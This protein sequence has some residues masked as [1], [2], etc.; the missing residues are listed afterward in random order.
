MTTMKRSVLG[1]LILF[2]VSLCVHATHPTERVSSSYAEFFEGEF[3]GV[4]LT[5]DGRLILAPAIVEKLDTLE[6][7]VYSAVVDR[8]GSVFVGTGNNGKKIE[9]SHPIS[10]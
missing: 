9:K 5:S 4:S 6:A 7:F 1:V 3:K 8:T 10:P 2:S